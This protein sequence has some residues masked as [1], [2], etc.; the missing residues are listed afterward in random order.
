MFLYKF[1]YLSPEITLFYHGYERHASIFSGILTILLSL[2]IIL[3]IIILS[4][5]FIFKK[6]P[7]AYYYN[8]YVNDLDVFHLNSTGI[9]LF[10]LMNDL[11]LIG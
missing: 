5:D 11:P 3:L 10:A 9:F 6:N 1:D 8:K 7:T 2:F 4:I